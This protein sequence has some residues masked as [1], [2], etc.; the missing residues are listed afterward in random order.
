MS[1]PTWSYKH[2][3]I[4]FAYGNDSP[5]A[6]IAT[7]I[8]T[9]LVELLKTVACV[10][11]MEIEFAEPSDAFTYSGEDA[12]A[13]LARVDA[14]TEDLT[15]V[16]IDCDLL[17][18]DECGR[19]MTMPRVL[20]C[21]LEFGTSDIFSGRRLLSAM[22]WLDVDVHVAVQ[23]PDRDN[24]P[25]AAANAPAFNRFLA[26]VPAVLGIPLEDVY[27]DYYNYFPELVNLDGFTIVPVATS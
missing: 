25:L 24:R 1:N 26:C 2:G 27:S 12:A 21:R 14:N 5:S 3:L 17:F 6:E 18:T 4:G 19:Q 9:R 13:A 10:K 15:E 22:M 8:V 16:A 20:R 7:E 11:S 23:W